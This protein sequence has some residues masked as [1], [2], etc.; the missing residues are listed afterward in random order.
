MEKDGLT[1]STVFNKKGK[2]NDSQANKRII[3]NTE[4]K[5]PKEQPEYRIPDV[6]QMPPRPDLPR[7]RQSEDL[8]P[9][10]T[11]S[12]PSQPQMPTAQE[13]KEPQP[14]ATPPKP[15][16][17]TKVTTTKSQAKNNGGIAIGG[18]VLK[19]ALVTLVLVLFILI[20]AR[21]LGF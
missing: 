18:D 21:L 7:L 20:I 13:T 11:L 10:F 4:P 3:G 15:L 2:D 17:K 8:T 6:P 19:G 12:R 5:E 1:I 16:A 9:Q 14:L